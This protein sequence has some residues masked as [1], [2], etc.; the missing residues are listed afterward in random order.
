MKLFTAAALFS[1]CALTRAHGRFQLDT[2]HRLVKR[3]E[4]QPTGTL[5]VNSPA[6]GYFQ[7]AVNY[8]TG[9][10]VTV[11]W[12]D[13][14]KNGNVQVALM[15]NNSEVL[16]YNITQAPPTVPQN[17]CDSDEGLGVA[18]SGRTCGRVEFLMPS[19]V[20]TGNYSF[21]VN[22]LPP[23]PYEEQYTD[24]VLVTH[25]RDDV[26]FALLPLK[27]ADGQTYT[28]TAVG[29]APASSTSSSAAAAPSTNGASGATSPTTAPA[30]ST[31][32]SSQP[33]ATTTSVKGGAGASLGSPLGLIS[34]AISAASLCAASALLFP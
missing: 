9:Q 26:P 5:Y 23:A 13:A 20:A 10:L 6:C 18:V 33:A 29:D 2:P 3:Q 19:L 28:P 34:L 14:P 8:T 30:S 1:L 25:T 11:N 15:T 31:P 16:A 21:R 27:G 12:L 7:C 17:Y 24:V 4:P 32:A 22:S